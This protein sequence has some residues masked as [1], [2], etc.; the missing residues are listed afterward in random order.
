MM[1]TGEGSILR[2]SFV[3]STQEVK[4]LTPNTSGNYEI[5]CCQKI[6]AMR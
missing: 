5:L 6:E 1:F 2:Q 3:Q 4:R